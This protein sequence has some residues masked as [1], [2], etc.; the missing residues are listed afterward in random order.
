MSE[1]EWSLQPSSNVTIVRAVVEKLLDMKSRQA[2][3]LDAKYRLGVAQ[4]FSARFLSLF[5]L[6]SYEDIELALSINDDDSDF[7]TMVNRFVNFDLYE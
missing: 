3:L 1:K 5:L 4:E 2:H 6:E 7:T